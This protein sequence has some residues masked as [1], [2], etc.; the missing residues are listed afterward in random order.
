MQ[1]VYTWVNGKPIKNIHNILLLFVLW[2]DPLQVYNPLI[3]LRCLTALLQLGYINSLGME[4][5]DEATYYIHVHVLQ[6]WL[7]SYILTIIHVLRIGY[8]IHK[9]AICAH[10]LHEFVVAPRAKKHKR[11]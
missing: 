8:W 9:S 6:C 11:V 5:G 1:I 4:P 7:P 10:I 2:A 3:V